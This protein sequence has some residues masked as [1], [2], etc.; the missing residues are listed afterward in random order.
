MILPERNMNS[1]LPIRSA[2]DC[3]LE[4]SQPQSEGD[5]TERRW[6]QHQGGQSFRNHMA[7]KL[8]QK[9]KGQQPRHRPKCY[10]GGSTDRAALS[11]E[12]NKEPE[13]MAQAGT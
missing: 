2:V 4:L 13:R 5:G 8:P 6:T 7:E 9:E 12:E 11:L 3:L 10:K 1:V